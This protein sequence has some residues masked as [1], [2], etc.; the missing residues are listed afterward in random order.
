MINQPNASATDVLS[1]ASSSQGLAG[2]CRGDSLP[3]GRA[4]AVL[5]LVAMTALT[6]LAVPEV[7]EVSAR[8]VTGTRTVV[9]TYTLAQPQGLPCLV[10]LLASRNNGVEW[11][12]ITS[13]SGDV[14]AGK[15]STSSGAAKSITWI[16]ATDWPALLIPQV[17]IRITASDAQSGGSAV[18]G[19]VHIPAG[20]FTMGN[21]LSSTND[22]TS[23]ELPTHTVTL[24]AFYLATTEAT[25]A[26]WDIIRAWAATR[27]YTDLVAGGGKAATHPVQTVSWYDVVKWCNA[28][29]EREGLTP[30]YYTN[31]AQTTA[32]RTGTVDVALA[33]VNWA[34]NGYRLPTEAEWEFAARGGLSGKRFP[35]GDTITHA[36]ANYFSSS[37][38]TYDV[39]PTRGYH[40][41]Y[42]TGSPPNTSPVG[43]FQANEYGLFDMAGNVW[44]LVWDGY[45]SYSSSAQTNPRRPTSILGRVFRGGSWQGSGPRVAVR[46][47]AYG[48]ESVGF[49]SARNSISFSKESATFALDLRPNTS[50]AITLHPTAVT[51]LAGNNTSFS[52]SAS[53]AA[54]LSYQ[55]RK[56]GSP[57]AGATDGSFSLTGVSSTD[58]GSYTVT[59]TNVAGSSISRAATLSVTLPGR[60]INLSVLTDIVSAGDDFTLGYVIGGT[61][62]FGAKPLV[63]R[64]A[65]PSLGAIGVPGTLDDPKL[66][67]FAGSISTGKNDNWG[68]STQLAATMAAV[69]AFAYAGPFSSDAAVSDNI[70]TR[71]NS[72][73]VSAVGRGTGKVIAE[74]YDATP[75]ALFTTSTRRFINVSVRK[76]LGSGV[77][78]G[79][80]VGGSSAAKVLVRGIGPTLGAFGVAD[81]VV[82]PQ[83][84]LFNSF[85][86]KIGEN[87][88]WGGTTELTAAFVTVGAFALPVTSKDAAL[89]V[90]LQPGN[91]TT[92]VTGLNGTTGVA[93][94]EVYEVP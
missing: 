56:D 3:C 7:S 33:Q 54:P 67:L 6:A 49:R 76:H 13:A 79:F 68:G 20:T 2:V 57:I 50:P 48:G 51:V 89:L 5:S 92:E 32:Y 39:S 11:E 21:S 53:G 85:N 30:V 83:L 93:L 78:M 42:S 87:N 69:G 40:P 43:S 18:A 41:A 8:H 62:T 27:G 28:K 73:K 80:V 75:S 60:L 58:I 26:E 37:N 70:T 36:Q 94:V 59:V 61:D 29:S 82:D 74:I 71:D 19:M 65:G 88:D 81:T 84:T 17:K 24:S 63:I 1:C 22:G 4:L 14:G 10:T 66:E 64:A 72:V 45:N 46:G 23:V 77:T 47:A 38:M 55:W 16:A 25:K 52:V 91:Y 12:T 35:W 86:V 9:I 90:T 31:D 34:A 44:E 15:S